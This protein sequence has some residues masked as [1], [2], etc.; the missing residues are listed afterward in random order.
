LDQLPLIRQ[1]V[2]ETASAVPLGSSGTFDLKVAVSEASANAIEHGL[3]DGDLEVSAK[4]GH[5]RLTITVCP[6]GGFRPRI[7]GDPARSHRGMGFPL[8]LALINE[9]TVTR[10]R[11][12]GTRVK[13]SVFLD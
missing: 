11:H 4:H 12:G 6:P 8:M 3:G 2:E 13:L 5:G 10:P 9:L 1:F 7:D